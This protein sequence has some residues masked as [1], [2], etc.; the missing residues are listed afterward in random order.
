MS[1]AHFIDFGDSDAKASGGPKKPLFGWSIV[2]ACTADESCRVLEWTLPVD[3]SGWSWLVY[4]HMLVGENNDEKDVGFQ[5]DESARCHAAQRPF[6]LA[7]TTCR[8]HVLWLL[9][10]VAIR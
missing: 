1:Q 3:E 10:D 8:N 9:Y 6:A 2:S 7:R 4:P 5:Q